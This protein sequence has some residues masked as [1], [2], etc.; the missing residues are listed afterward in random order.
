MSVSIPNA[1]TMKALETD[2]RIAEL[3][4]GEARGRFAI[5][6]LKITVQFAGFGPALASCAARILRRA[7]FVANFAA[8]R[9]PAG[10][11]FRTPR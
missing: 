8:I 1:L 6:L 4:E 11:L 2:V 5:D 3:R 7:A 10:L 9:L